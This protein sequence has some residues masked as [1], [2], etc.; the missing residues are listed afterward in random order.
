[1]MLRAPETVPP[2]RLLAFPRRT[3]MSLPSGALPAA[4]RPMRF[5]WITLPTPLEALVATP[6]R[7]PEITLPAPGRRTADRGAR[8]A[9]DTNAILGIAAVEV[10]GD[11]GAD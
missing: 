8:R 9:A 1:M 7:L 4:F 5:P 3:P 2:R 10:T 11:I 6:M